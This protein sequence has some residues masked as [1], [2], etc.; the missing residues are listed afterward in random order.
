M[1]AR[2]T[3][4]QV[5]APAA[6]EEEERAFGDVLWRVSTMLNPAQGG[7]FAAAEEPQTAAMRAAARY[8]GKK[9]EGGALG[10]DDA[11]EMIERLARSAGLTAYAVKLTEGWEKRFALPMVAR[12]AADG[13]PVALTPK[14][15]AWLLTEGQIA[16][17]PKRLDSTARAGLAEE[18]FALCPTLPEGKI[19]LKT[20]FWYALGPKLRDLS[21]YTLMTFL[22]GLVLAL[23]PIAN[24]AVTEII[25]P[26][27]DTPL[28]VHVVAMLIA[29]VLAALATRLA[30]EL[31]MLRLNGRAGLMLRVAAADRMIRV[32]RAAG[33]GAAV[34]P[35]AA[36]LVTRSV[37]GW[38]R[39]AWGLALRIGAAALIAL[40]SLAVMMRAAPTA[41]LTAVALMLLATGLAAWTAKRQVAALFAGPSSPTSWISLSHEA[42]SQLETLRAYGAERRFFTMFA[43][44]FLALKERFLVTD[45]MGSRIHA[46]EKSLEGGVIATGIGAAIL[47]H[48]DMPVQ[49][50]VAFTVALM[51]VTGAAVTLVHSF[52]DVSMLGLQHKMIQPLLEKT[53][54]PFQTGMVPGALSGRVTL[55][56]VTVR[57]DP[58]ARPILDHVSLDIKPG[59]HIAIVG[60][61]GS[62]KTTL[63]RTILGLQT[64]EM[65]QVRYDGIGLDQLDAAA[66]R[67]QIGVVGQSGQL[68]PGTILENIALGLK[69]DIEDAWRALQKAAID[70]EIRALPLGLSTPIGDAGSVFSGGQVQRILIAR[71][72]A[73]APRIVIL[74]EATSALDPA[75]EAHVAKALDGLKSTTITVAHRLE[76]IRHCDCIHV[77]DAGR[78]VESGTYAEL[79]ARGGIFAGLVAAD[80][81]AAQHTP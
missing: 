27:R 66:V 77:L 29:L 45:R 26:G 33:G 42:L 46:L 54:A 76:T 28:L 32:T 8:Y 11:G 24:I 78:I 53:P 34:P 49:D 14:G 55:D 50:S 59:E 80:A 73:Q 25:I 64:L 20:L 35:G 75:R 51:T 39:G 22:A 63:L 30:A 10:G 47:F 13:T 40:P 52:L 18:A 70:D 36:A 9:P 15:G 57:R 12:L 74:D 48:Q 69:L 3:S 21:G 72:L 1:E 41:A 79:L 67:R 81:R 19:T 2:S 68:F 65:G 4:A 17:A 38:H 71:A 60:P 37:E 31:S 16:H 5:P 7:S 58:H 56:R 62:G 43:Q 6:I 44:S 23:T 61:S